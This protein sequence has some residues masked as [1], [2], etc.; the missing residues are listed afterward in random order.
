VFDDVDNCQLGIGVAAVDEHVLSGHEITVGA[1][2]KDE[3]AK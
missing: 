1:S 3:R 2:Q